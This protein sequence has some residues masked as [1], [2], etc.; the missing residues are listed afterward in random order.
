MPIKDVGFNLVVNYPL[1][2]EKNSTW[3]IIFA[4]Q[5]ILMTLCFFR[6][7]QRNYKSIKTLLPL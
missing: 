6:K 2:P 5:C 7:K 3:C 4:V 1:Q